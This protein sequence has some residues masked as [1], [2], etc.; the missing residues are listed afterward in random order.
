MRDLFTQ[1]RQTIDLLLTKYL[2]AAISYQGIQRVEFSPLPEEALREAVLNALIHHDYAVGAP[3][4][5]RACADRLST[6]NP[7]ELPEGWS[8]ATLLRPHASRPYNPL[9]ARAFFRTGEIEAW[10]RGVLRVRGDDPICAW[11]PQS[12]GVALARARAACPYVQAAP[13]FISNPQ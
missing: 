13:A 9:A 12:P 6:W 7:G 3:I 1:A 11:R 2:K 4:Q 8:V 10:G 5:I